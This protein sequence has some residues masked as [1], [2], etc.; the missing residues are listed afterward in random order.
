[1]RLLLER[2]RNDCRLQVAGVKFASVCRPSSCGRAAQS[3][4]V[5]RH[6]PSAACDAS[7]A[8]ACS[9][10]YRAVSHSLSSA[11]GLREPSLD[12]VRL[13]RLLERPL[14]GRPVGM[15]AYG[16]SAPL[17]RTFGATRE[18]NCYF[19]QHYST[20]RVSS[21]RSRAAGRVVHAA[22]V[23]VDSYHRSARPRDCAADRAR[24]RPCRLSLIHI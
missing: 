21:R 8:A 22:I 18:N 2:R 19:T 7:R 20:S 23:R 1:M 5:S 6:A 24:T 16:R 3:A 17:T 10:W 12:G 4:S 9:W 13:P 14:Y 11:T 15:M